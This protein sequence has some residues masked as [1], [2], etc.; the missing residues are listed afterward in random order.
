LTKSPRIK[1]H[2]ELVI[3]TMREA[4]KPVTRRELDTALNGRVT[5]S[6]VGR[7]LEE[8]ILRGDLVKP[9]HGVYELTASTQILTPIR[10]EYLSIS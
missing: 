8:G 1:T 3:D 6:S 7:S 4:G 5:R 9:K 2:Y 10:D